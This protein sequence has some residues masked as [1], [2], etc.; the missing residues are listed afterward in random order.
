M[1][2]IFFQARI[3]WMPVVIY[4]DL[5]FAADAPLNQLCRLNRLPNEN[6]DEKNPHLE[7]SH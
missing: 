4:S 2:Q 5:I 1:L 6:G 3:A 7:N